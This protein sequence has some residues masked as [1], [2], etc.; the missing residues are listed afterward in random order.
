MA[1]GILKETCYVGGS[2]R[3]KGEEVE[4][5]DELAADFLEASERKETVESLVA[6][7]SKGELLA[8]ALSLKLKVTE[9]SNEDEIAAKIVAKLNK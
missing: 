9:D 7:N 4:V 8:W 1:K 6:N 5:K 2:L 3:Q